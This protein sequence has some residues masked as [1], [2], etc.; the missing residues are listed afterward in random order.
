MIKKNLFA[1]LLFCSF[2]TTAQNLNLRFNH[3]NVTTGLSASDVRSVTQDSKGF[4]WIATGNGLNKY[5]GYSYTIYKHNPNNSNS[6]ID[7]D[8]QEVFEDSEGNLWIGTGTGVCMYQKDKNIFVAHPEVEG[9][10]VFN[11]IEDKNKTL[12]LSMGADVYIYNRKSKSFSVLKSFPSNSQIQSIYIDSSNSFWVI[13]PSKVYTLDVN[14]RSYKEQKQI[15]LSNIQELTQDHSGEI[16]FAA[17]GGLYIYNHQSKVLK[18]YEKNNL[19]KKTIVTLFEDNQHQIWAGSINDGL[20]ILNKNGDKFYHYLNQ[21]GDSESLSSNSINDVFA[22]KNNNIWLST[23]SDGVNLVTKKQIETYRTNTFS[24]NSLSNDNIS[25]FSEDNSGNI[26]IGTDGGGLNKFNPISKTFQQFKTEKGNKNSISANVVTSILKDKQGFLWLGYW[27]GGLDK[28]NPSTHQFIHYTNKGSG[29]LLHQSVMYLYEDRS[30]NLWVQTFKGLM[31][32]NK[33]TNTFEDYTSPKIDLTN[34]IASMLDDR[35]GNLWLGTW[36]GLNLLDRKT[37]KY[38]AFKHRDKDRQSL[39]NDKINVIFED[40]KGRLWIGTGDGLNLFNKGTKTFTG[41]YEEDGLPSGTIYGILED[42]KG[43]LWLSTSHGICRY[44]PET[45][46][47]K[48]LTSQDGLQG[49]EFKLNAFLKLKNGDFVFGGTKGFTMFNPD[50]IVENKIAPQ[51]VF[52]DLQV[53]NTSVTSYGSTSPLQKSVTEA[54]EIHL[55]YKQS[56]FTL[57]FSA[58]NYLSPQDNQYAYKLEGFDKE[59]N[60]VGAQRK[61]TYT[62]LDPGTYTFKVKAANNDGVWNEKGASIVIIITPPFWKT[63]WFRILSVF[64]IFGLAYSFYQHRINRIKKQ[65]EELERQ[66]EERTIE[67]QRQANV[68]QDLNEELQSQSEEL[69]T[70]SVELKEQAEEL[71][72]QAE[73]L[74]QQSILEQKAREEAEKANQAKSTFLATMSHEIRTPM[75]G[76]LGMASLLCETNLDR[77]Q[78][79]YA[80]T[81]KNSGEALLTV[82]NDILDFSKIESGNLELDPH[83]FDLRKC[84]EEVMDL[85]SAKTAQLGLDLVYLIDYKIPDQ[86]FGDSLRLRQVLINL[87]GNSIKFTHSGE[88]YI[89]VSLINQDNDDLELAFEV[90]D[91]GIGIPQDKLSRLFKA[92]S[93]V[94]SSTTR[95]YGGTG[96]GLVI[97]ERLVKLM[98][99][100][101]SVESEEGKGTSFKFNLSCKI[102]NEVRKP[103]VHYGISDF[104]GKRV[105]IIDDNNTNLKILKTQ[106]ERWKLATTSA[107]SG[108]AALKELEDGKIFDM[109]ISDMQMPEMDGVELSRL[110][111]ENIPSLPIVLLSSIGDETQKKYGHIFSAI[112]TKPV[113]QQQL[114]RVLQEQLNKYEVRPEVQGEKA[115]VLLSDDF[116]QHNPLKILIAEDNLIN[117]K[118]ISKILS[119]LGYQSQM[120]NN[121]QEVIDEL[122][123]EHYDVILMDVQMPVMDGLEATKAIRSDF[124]KQPLIVAM[125]ANA[126]IEDKEIC[127]DAGMDEYVSKPIKLEELI[128]VLSEVSK[129]SRISI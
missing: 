78:K 3:L 57:E 13:T 40:S 56:V 85:F 107:S 64:L 58:L 81:I 35:D 87:V 91:T 125:T 27:D 42:R 16:W 103:N 39:S 54:K 51:V 70:Q 108:K 65:K 12:Y 43:S 1:I 121:G 23:Y 59:W 118:L 60:Y 19:L 110:I 72:T 98:G 49:N 123:K 71:Q 115:A 93:Q 25:S 41:I 116:A 76:V 117:Q 36:A 73:E 109:V 26:W 104:E 62:N 9:L 22:D 53:F 97:C 90:R 77:E 102:S 113:K 74:K 10:R 69:Q 34:Y 124:E 122:H 99:G 105:L 30:E 88:V 61:V 114:L 84:I 66:V 101:I 94:D 80:E 82:I 55:S 111:K 18:P 33:K 127:F 14:A 44:N 120:A 4:I 20:Y 106:L 86:I 29:S 17:E 79:D 37:K 8:V 32:L 24:K 126:M 50:E 128:R 52:I 47:I 119:K 11:F 89:G 31:L 46:A 21:P 67:I 6:L 48:T 96:L 63:W 7:N 15:K 112:L 5:D 68:L 75:N 95:K 2:C 129:K 92:F 38:T 100:E 45:K 83:H 28:Y